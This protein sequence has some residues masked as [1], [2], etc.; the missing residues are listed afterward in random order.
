MDGF[1]GSNQITIRPEDQNKMDFIY[2][3]VTFAYKMMP[4]G[5][6]NVGANFLWAMS[7]TFYD[8]I[9]IIEAYLDD[10]DAYSRKRIDHPHHL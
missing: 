1:S 4:F 5:L 7:Y 3:W 6:K 8:I 2:P 10:L 9:R